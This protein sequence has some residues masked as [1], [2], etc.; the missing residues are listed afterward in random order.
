[1]KPN[2]VFILADDLGWRDLSA[3]GSEFHESPNIDRIAKE[4]MRFTQGYATCQ[5]CSPSRASIMTGKYT[6]RH[7]ITDYIGGKSGEAWRENGQFSKML[8]PEY[9][10]GLRA[11]EITFAEVF[12]RS[13]YRTFF[14]GKWHLG[15]EGAYPEDFGFQINK[16]GW[17]AGG[18]NGRYF[19][20]WNNPKLEPG[21]VGESLPLRLG[22]ETAR[23]IT[24]SKDAPFL[25]YLSFYS[26]HGPIQTDQ[27]RWDKFRKKAVAQGTPDHRFIFDRNQA[28]RQVQDCPIYG[29]MIEAMDDAVGLVLD[30]L[31]DLE[32]T[33]NTIVCFT[34]DNGGVSSGD[35]YASSMLPFRGGKGRQWEGGIREP[36]YFRY[37]GVIEVGSTCDIPVSGIDFYPTFTELAG[38]AIPP[39]QVMD[40]KSIVPLLNSKH[41]EEIATRDLYWHYPHYG[42]QGGEPSSIIRS[43]SWKLI[44]YHEDGHD[45]LYNLD[46]DPGE[47]N[48]MI[49][50]N[51]ER[52]S[53]LRSRLDTWLADVEA[54]FPT[55]D[56]QYD[57]AKENALLH[58]REHEWMPELEAN[59]AEYL[60]PNWQPND[61]WWGSQITID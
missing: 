21:P 31:D 45:E 40:G 25:A 39:E 43:G 56:P 52:G 42:N 36:L 6:P 46:S 32:L 58:S 16:G 14:A 19:A 8:P 27:K 48:D 29:G 15:D 41:D 60:D 23:F 17:S 33:D 13:G 10:H 54:K 4:G 7:G 47:Q 61:D 59:H 49:A 44:Y 55:P 2:I 51:Q 30:T 20:P 53:E 37:P 3:D 50:E 34:S 57:P 38:V 11:D 24:D 26:V 35:S 22:R 18:P 28:V 12:R 9:E 1:M 5:V